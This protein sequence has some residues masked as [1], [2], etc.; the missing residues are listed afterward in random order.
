MLYE[1]MVGRLPFDG[2]NPA[3]VLRRVLDGQFTP[4][5]RA[6]PTV[7]AGYSA[8]LSRALA[9]AAEDRYAS[10]A[11]FALALRGELAAVGVES[12]RR[13]L[14]AFL[15]D[16]GAYREDHEKT[17]VLRLTARGHWC[18]WALR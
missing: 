9:H 4:A 11:E 2:K 7:G 1:A 14:H 18:W 12:P 5:E 16:A 6:R 13:E 8:V 3:Q 17:I 15:V 10:A